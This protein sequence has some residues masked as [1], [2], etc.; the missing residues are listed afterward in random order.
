MAA[1]RTR[2][3][4]QIFP[5]CAQREPRPRGGL[6]AH[7]AGRVRPAR[8][9]LVTDGDGGRIT[10]RQRACFVS[11]ASAATARLAGPGIKLHRHGPGTRG[12]PGRSARTVQ[13]RPFSR[14]VYHSVPRQRGRRPL[15]DGARDAPVP[16][17]WRKSRLLG[18]D[19][20]PAGA[21]ELADLISVVRASTLPPAER[22]KGVALIAG[23]TAAPARSAAGPKGAGE[24]SS[25]T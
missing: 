20:G 3:R 13:V 5:I 8:Q 2:G 19:L 12:G 16:A 25:P 1:F 24:R 21:E 11:L 7:E 10:L 4:Q 15:H 14:R 6:A 17:T 22:V 18:G 23:R 9:R